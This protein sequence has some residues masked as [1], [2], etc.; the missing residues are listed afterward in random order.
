MVFPKYE[1]AESVFIII[2]TQNHTY[3]RFMIQ[4]SCDEKVKSRGLMVILSERPGNFTRSDQGSAGSTVDLHPPC[5]PLLSV[6]LH[7][8]ALEITSVLA[9]ETR[10]RETRRG[11]IGCKFFVAVSS[12][13]RRFETLTCWSF[14][15]LAQG[16][17]KPGSSK[18]AVGGLP[19]G[20]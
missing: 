5:S 20:C 6:P 12:M 4:E 19:E 9:V 3:G 15:L 1:R 11:L 2:V 13:R 14:S 16:Y 17:H 8:Q 7:L 18:A 10:P